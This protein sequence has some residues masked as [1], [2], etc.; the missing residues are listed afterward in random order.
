LLVWLAAL[1]LM[2]AALTACGG[3]GSAPPA[4]GG[5]TVSTPSIATPPLDVSV[6]EGDSAT[7]SVTANG[8]APLSYQWQ[9][10]GADVAGATA[11]Q[12]TLAAQAADNGS[13]WTVIVRNSAG[14]VT[15]SAAKLT[16]ATK[17]LLAGS[18]QNNGLPGYV[19]L[20]G[21]AVDDAGNS[22]ITDTYK[23]QL[24]RK[25]T[26]QG[27]VSTLTL[28]APAGSAG[29]ALHGSY[30]LARDG[31]GN[32]Y[33][34][35]G[36]CAIYKATPDGAV[37]TLAGSGTCGS[38]DG[39]GS[40]A[41]FGSID[42]LTADAAGNV[43]VATN[44]TIRK[45]APDGT[46]ST[47]AGAAGQPSSAGG[48][49]DGDARTAR[50]GVLLGITVDSAGNLYAIDGG[51]QYFREPRVR[52]LTPAG[53]VSTVAGPTN[54]VPDVPAAAHFGYLRGPVIDS[55]GN[56]Y[57]G[58]VAD[59][60]I[61]K[62]TPNGAVSVLAGSPSQ[63]VTQAVDG[64]G[65]AAV[66]NRIAALAIDGAGNIYVGESFS[67]VQYAGI[68]KVT[69]AAVV[70]TITGS[71]AGMG[72]V[73]G[74]GAAARFTSPRA[75]AVRS[76]G[77]VLVAD[78]G[79]RLIRQVSPAGAVTTLAGASSFYRPYAI[80]VGSDGSAYVADA[81]RNTISKV[82]TSGVVTTLAGSYRPDTPPADGQGTAANFFRTNGIAVD[83]SGAVL[84]AD[85]ST[86]RKIDAAG[87][88]TTLTGTYPS[89][90][91]T[92]ADG[93]LAQARFLAVSAIA[94]DAD[95]NLYVTD[96]ENQNVRKISKDGVVS[97]LA[98]RTRVAGDA[99]GPAGTA[100]FNAPEGIA[101]DK[102]GN[103][104]V[105]DTQN[106][107]IRKISTGGVVTTVAGKRGL[108]GNSAGSP[109]GSLNHPSGLAFD[110]AG[111]LYVTSANGIFKLQL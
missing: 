10:N 59:G 89:S 16:I 62:I 73:D 68:R 54:A 87:N 47:L 15:S 32:F 72:T 88:V 83:R 91:S 33:L 12:Y 92:Y 11:A 34:D 50:F 7:F 14:S 25:V 82:S 20:T 69:P 81:D 26:P 64:T 95:G 37:T 55:Q 61:K 31:A 8:T 52:K 49:D 56:L 39:K 79:D 78:T 96:M 100:T 21:I 58:E 71:V 65:T 75:L 1:L 27:V 23:P 17:T 36:D 105:A 19:N 29:A 51:I 77:T 44:N 93:T 40:A 30:A 99:D 38:A 74:Q 48:S 94:A 46:V 24:L 70:T 84:V 42:A 4:N 110:A 102:A 111:A 106:N 13:L 6:A 18:Q 97:T 76:D 66:F 107:L 104:Y 3:G 85:A 22:Y 67:N 101:V 2:A 5:G 35:G 43:Y 103:V 57:V 80:A 109:Y 60:T 41:G 45:V 86:I 63:F 108:T 28:S 9:R 90:D 98:G 53:V